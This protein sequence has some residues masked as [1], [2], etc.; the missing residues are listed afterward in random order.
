MT[1]AQPGAGT[2]SASLATGRVLAATGRKVAL[3]AAAGD[4]PIVPQTD[5]SGL[6]LLAC[7][8][9]DAGQATGDATRLVQLIAALRREY[10]VVIVDIPPIL[11]SGANGPLLEAMDALVL[12]ARWRATPVRAVREAMH[13]IA[14]AGGKVSGVA[15]SMVPGAGR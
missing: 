12:L 13:R 2:T 15:L 5:T 7:A 10:E 9:A 6:A 1:A 8:I 14:V 11:T 4:G 3:I